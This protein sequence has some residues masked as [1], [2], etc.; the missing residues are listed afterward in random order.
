MQQILSL[1]SRLPNF[2]NVSSEDKVIELEPETVSCPLTP[3][4]I[5]GPVSSELMQFYYSQRRMFGTYCYFFSD[6]FVS[7]A[8]FALRG[9]GVVLS[10]EL[11]W[12]V[13]SISH[14]LSN[15]PKYSKIDVIRRFDRS[16]LIIGD[17]YKIYGHWLVDI[18]PKISIIEALGFDVEQQQYLLP[19]DTPSFGIEWLRL[20]G[21]KPENI[22]FFDPDREGVA[23]NHLIIPT[24]AR[25][26]SRAKPIFEPAVRRI[27]ERLKSTSNWPPPRNYRRLFLSRGRNMNR[28]LVNRLEVEV[29]FASA[30][31]Y[32]VNP[33]RLSIVEQIALFKGADTIVGEYGSAMHGSIFSEP[34]T[35]IVCLR[36]NNHHPGF[37]QSGI[38]QAL[39]QKVSYVFGRNTGDMGGGSEYFIDKKDIYCAL[40]MLNA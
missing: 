10:R 25:T 26:N 23:V 4:F 7:G 5:L 19:S 18:L 1:E 24:M 2:C 6:V 11:H 9:D 30:G 22:I 14:Y 17:G 28:L 21:I 13:K 36:S 16:V 38:C 35:R 39:N 37:L 3:D 27:K 20:F 12:S 8:G 29:A 32:V 40:E 31:Y 33:E 34:G 15:R